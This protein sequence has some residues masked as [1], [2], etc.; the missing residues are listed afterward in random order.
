[1]RRVGRRCTSDQSE[2]C[3]KRPLA[4]VPNPHIL[5]LAAA[6]HFCLQNRTDTCVLC[7]VVLVGSGQPYTP[8]LFRHA[9][10]THTGSCA[11]A[12]ARSTKRVSCSSAALLG[13][14]TFDGPLVD[15]LPSLLSRPEFSRSYLVLRGLCRCFSH[16]AQ[17]LTVRT[18]DAA[19]PWGLDLV[20]SSVGL[21][22]RSVAVQAKQSSQLPP[23]TNDIISL[24]IASLPAHRNSS[25]GHGHAWP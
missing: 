5:H 23:T 20:R 19:D 17:S 15:F 11:P 18:I 4:R 14:A 13:S 12:A 25:D 6:R 7:A 24:I 2:T 21:A 9:T 8:P 10:L 22:D 1:M 3:I 16:I